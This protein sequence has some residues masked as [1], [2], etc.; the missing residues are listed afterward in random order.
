MEKSEKKDKEEEKTQ[1]TAVAVGRNLRISRKSSVEIARFIRGKKAGKAIAELEKVVKKERFI[2][3]TRYMSNVGHRK[4]GG[5]GKFPVK[6][7]Q[8]FIKVIKN[9]V[10]NA[11][12]SG[13]GDN[14]Y[15]VESIVNNGRRF[16]TPKR[17]IGRLP[18]ITHI[19]IRLEER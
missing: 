7:S 1:T 9:G 13:L 6:A 18:K 16:R 3:F 15:I 14:L 10:E 12:Y 11:K 2:P 19:K 5:I 4:G 8:E 17:H